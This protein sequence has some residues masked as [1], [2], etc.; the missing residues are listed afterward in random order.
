MIKFFD[1]EMDGR[2][3]YPD[4]MQ[5]ILP[6]TNSRLR[7]QATQRYNIPCSKYE[8]LT[9]DVEK[10]LSELILTEIKMHRQTEEIK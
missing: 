5:L 6:C 4:F 7:E 2:I 10:E 8:Y 9:L 1:S 3:N